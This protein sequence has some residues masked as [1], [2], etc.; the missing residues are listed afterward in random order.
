M[1]LLRKVD[2]F[3]NKS[4]TKAS[5]KK[6]ETDKANRQTQTLNSMSVL[7]IKYICCTKSHTA[8]RKP[9]VN[10]IYAYFL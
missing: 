10:D 4:K 9:N 6:T 7:L 5:M 3:T 1:E 2:Y 8:T